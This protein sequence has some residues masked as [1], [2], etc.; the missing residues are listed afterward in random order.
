V[1]TGHGREQ[2][3]KLPSPEGL[4]PDFVAHGLNQAVRWILRDLEED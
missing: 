1:L 2:M 4:Y 3:D